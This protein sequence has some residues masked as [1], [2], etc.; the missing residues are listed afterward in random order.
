MMKFTLSFP[1]DIGVSSGQLK[2]LNEYVLILNVYL[3]MKRYASVLI[4]VYP[5]KVT[6]LEKGLRHKSFPENLANFFHIF[7][8]NISG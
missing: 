5:F 8:H 3:N 2:R 1:A 4:I 6:L 7:S